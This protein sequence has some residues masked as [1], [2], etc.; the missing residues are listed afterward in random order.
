MTAYYLNF[1]M[2]VPPR[3]ISLGR[4]LVMRYADRLMTEINY[5]NIQNVTYEFRDMQKIN[6]MAHLKPKSFQDL[7]NEIV[8]SLK[9]H[10]LFD[11]ILNARSYCYHLYRQNSTLVTCLT[12]RNSD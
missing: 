6:F 5:F 11:D 4:Q 7:P 1:C 2:D 10:S 9:T 8:Y 12:H 3:W